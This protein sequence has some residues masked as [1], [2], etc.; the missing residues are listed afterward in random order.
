MF[1]T[2]IYSTVLRNRDLKILKATAQRWMINGHGGTSYKIVFA[3]KKANK[4]VNVDAVWIHNKPYKV[5]VDEV[6]TSEELEL[7]NVMA[8]NLSESQT[9]LAKDEAP[10]PEEV[11]SQKGDAI[12]VYTIGK[13]KRYHIIPELTQLPFMMAN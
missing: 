12:I 10:L 6:G 3:P 4:K 2:F 1:I 13:K 7:Q 11:P 5:V 8:I 9:A